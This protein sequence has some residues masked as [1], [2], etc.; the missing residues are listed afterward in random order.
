MSENQRTELAASALAGLTTKT[1]STAEQVTGGKH[2]ANG[3][4]ID[5]MCGLI[6]R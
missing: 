3:C 2:E 5:V 1:E 6:D 4:G